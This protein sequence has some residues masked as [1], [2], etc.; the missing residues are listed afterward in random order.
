MTIIESIAKRLNLREWQIQAVL[1]LFDQGATIPF[2][3]HYRKHL[4]GNL[5]EEQLR[6]IKQDFQSQTSLQKK[7][8]ELLQ[9]LTD[10]NLLQDTLRDSVVNASTLTSL[11]ELTAPYQ[12]LQTNED[13]QT[14][15]I[16]QDITNQ[17]LSA[18]GLA[19]PQ[20]FAPYLDYLRDTLARRL[21]EN[22]QWHDW[23]YAQVE[24]NGFLIATPT[25][26]NTKSS[27]RRDPLSKLSTHRILTLLRQE[28]EGD[29]ELSIS[30]K[31]A[32]LEDK[33][34]NSLIPPH[35]PIKGYLKAMIHKA[36]VEFLLPRI[37]QELFSALQDQAYENALTTFAINYEDVLM[38]KPIKDQV[39]LAWDPGYRKGCKLVV[40]GPNG[41]VLDTLV[42]YPFC[43]HERSNL[44]LQNAKRKALGRIRDFL[45]CWEP[46][47]IVLGNGAGYVESTGFWMELLEDFPRLSYTIASKI[48]TSYYANSDQAKQEFPNLSSAFLP[49][50]SL[51]RR[52]QD[53]LSELIKMDPKTLGIGEHQHDLP[54]Q[55]LQDRLDFISEKVVNRIRVDVNTASFALLKH[56][57]GL[58]EKDVIQIIQAR[59]QA[60]FSNREQLK[61]ILSL[62]TY[63]QAIGFLCI[64][65]GTNPLDNTS[66]HPES[67]DLA[68]KVLKMANLTLD[69]F[70]QPTALK[71]LKA[72][73]PQ[74]L[75]HKLESDVYTIEH[76]LQALTN[77]NF[78]P[79]ESQPSYLLRTTLQSMKDLRRGMKLEGVV[80]NVT[81]FGAFV[82]IGLAEEGVIHIS[83]LANHF[84]SNPW[85]Y[86]RIGQIVQVYVQ[87]THSNQVALSLI[88][89][90]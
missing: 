58:N 26:Q 10:K 29:M 37:K 35:S 9:M 63:Q 65:D 72:L 17:L 38:V 80:R 57:S 79:R 21:S 83:Q 16:Y 50:I 32:P 12:S 40:L 90:N 7:K 8:T 71:Q 33:L 64:V 36:L 44:S 74:I 55:A 51:G 76:I 62:K 48:G 75:A 77:P 69:S 41:D 5:D 18:E 86:V 61:Q 22:L 1:D 20:S 34:A 66:I 4:T 84:V 81:S 70:N 2:I 23:V 82:D 14:Q 43:A 3:A 89:Q 46:S 25:A 49:A 56:V 24:K 85:E 54:A 15:A 30:I 60:K 53:P 42:V 31:K 19:H 67:Y 27:V 88:P 45:L 59:Q 13:L 39:V 11:Q 73:N 28:Q 87:A 52:V 6:K 78:D 68:L 47:L